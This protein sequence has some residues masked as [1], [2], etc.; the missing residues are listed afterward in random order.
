MPAQL[1]MAGVG[2]SPINGSSSLYTALSFSS[3]FH[4]THLAASPST[5]TRPQ[6][7]LHRWVPLVFSSSPSAA[8]LDHY[9]VL[10]LR[11]NAS[12]AH[13]KR[14]YRLLARKVLSNETTRTQYDRDLK[15]QEDTDRR[16]R[17]KWN[18]RPECEDR[19]R[20]YRWAEVRLKMQHER[21]WE[22]HSYNITEENPSYDDSDE[23]SEEGS[24][25]QEKGP[26]TEVLRS[27][28]ISIFI[29]RTFGSRWSLTFSSLMA[30]FDRRLDAGYKIGYVIAWILGGSG[31]VLLTLC[32]SFASWVCGKT[33]SSIV[34]LVVVAMWVA[35]SLARYAPLPQ[36]AL[37]TLL[38]MSIKLQVEL[39]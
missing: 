23:M 6:P 12:F 39:N 15:L 29:L 22:R 34:A 21:Y 7:R 25:D 11:R 14:A 37:L 17:G 27:A 1:L 35:S 30:M 26:F 36:G 24:M 20:I 3:T 8:H 19:A 28:F 38:Y 33:S 2:L 10:G 9:A 32:L 31:G 16:D 13:V 4:S 5:C 18:H